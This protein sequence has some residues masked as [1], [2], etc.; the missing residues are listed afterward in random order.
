MNKYFIPVLLLLINTAYPFEISYHALMGSILEDKPYISYDEEFSSR[1]EK[2]Y[3]GIGTQVSSF[4][5]YIGNFGQVNFGYVNELPWFEVQTGVFLGKDLKIIFPRIGLGA[6]YMYYNLSVY[7]GLEGNG[8]V[9]GLLPSGEYPRISSIAKFQVLFYKRLF[10]EW[11]L[12]SPDFPFW[13]VKL[14]YI[15]N[16]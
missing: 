9:A 12:R 8:H 5:T 14:G 11:E 2:G 6:S 1:S 4:Q 15:G 7:E 13:N 10:T 16:F 3:Y